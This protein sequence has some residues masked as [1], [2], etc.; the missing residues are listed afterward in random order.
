MG[1]EDLIKIVSRMKTQCSQPQLLL[2]F[3]IAEKITGNAE[4]AIRYTSINTFSELYEARRQSLKQ[5][6]SILSIKSKME[7]CKQGINESVQNFSLRFKQILN[8]SN[9]AVQSSSDDSERKLRLKIE[10]KEAISRYMLNLKRE[11]GIQVR[12]MKPLTLME[13]Q[14]EAAEYETRLKESQPNRTIPVIP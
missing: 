11:V 1:V 12:A 3:I 13:A 7:S 10:E 2:D 5:T 6:G 4:K 8:E 14:K 9:Y